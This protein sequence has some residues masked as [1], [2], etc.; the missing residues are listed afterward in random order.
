M[1]AVAGD[2]LTLPDFTPRPDPDG[3]VPARAAPRSPTDEGSLPAAARSAL[4]GAEKYRNPHR[5]RRL[6]EKS[7]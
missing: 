5:A 3:K 4:A 6:E 2:L 1:A 7:K